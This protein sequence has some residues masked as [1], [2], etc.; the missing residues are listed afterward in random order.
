MQPS[1]PIPTDNIYKFACLF[2]L[3]LIV[4]G[5]FAFVSSY[6]SALDRKVHY[7]EALI[8]LEAK[9]QRTKAEDAILAMNKNLIE[10]TKSNENV[11]NGFITVVL[12]IGGSLSFYGAG[13]WHSVIQKRDDQLASLQLRK[14]E[15]EVKRLEAE[16]VATAAQS[17]SS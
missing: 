6:S 3:V 1:I 8:P 10:V 14:L 5:I 15:A 7:S 11:A 17:I 16:V 9:A 4:A 2:G 12:V 13:K